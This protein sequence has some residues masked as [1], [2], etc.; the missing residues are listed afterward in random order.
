MKK[1]IHTKHLLLTSKEP[2]RGGALVV[3]ALDADAVAKGL[4]VK[5]GVEVVRFPRSKEPPR[6]GVAV[7]VTSA[8]SAALVV[9]VVSSFIASSIALSS[10][11]QCTV[12]SIICIERL[13]G[14]YI[15]SEES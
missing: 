14:I 8:P 13:R 11:A 6:G 7:V 9:V 3:V 12:N 15:D 1:K 5:G 10:L 2:S 4:V